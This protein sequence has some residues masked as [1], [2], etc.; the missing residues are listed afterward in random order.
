MQGGG[1]QVYFVCDAPLALSIFC[2]FSEQEG[3]MCINAKRERGGSG[4]E[5]NV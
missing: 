2:N 1:R 4:T 5:R 3:G